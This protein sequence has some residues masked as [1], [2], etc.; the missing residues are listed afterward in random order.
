MGQ[1]C[2]YIVDG[3]SG[4]LALAGDHEESAA[5]V[6]RLLADPA[7]AVRLGQ[8]AEQ[9][10]AERFSWGRLAAVAEEAYGMTRDP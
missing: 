6:L 10:L 7:L 4:L 3:V 5:A 9:R 1:N 8:G 2:E